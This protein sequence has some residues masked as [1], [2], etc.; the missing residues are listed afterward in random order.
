MT[1]APIFTKKKELQ[2][3]EH[4][5]LVRGLG[6]AVVELVDV[7]PGAGRARVDHERELDEGAAL[8]VRLGA[9]VGFCE[10]AVAHGVRRTCG[11][12]HVVV[13]RG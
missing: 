3:N 13:V 11:R 5:V 1:Q 9:V 7:D 6:P 10:V 4:L 2:L 8:L 12:R